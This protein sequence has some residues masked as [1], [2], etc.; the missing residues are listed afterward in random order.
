MPSISTKSKI[1]GTKNTPGVR[2]VFSGSTSKEREEVVQRVIEEGRRA[3]GEGAGGPILVPP[4]DHPDIILGQGTA[5]LEMEEQFRK[6]K[7]AEMSGKDGMGRKACSFAV[8][9]DTIEQN[10][11]TSTTGIESGTGDQP[12]FD[13]VLTPLGGGGLLGGTA[14]WFSHTRSPPP[15]PSSNTT[16][17]KPKGTLIFGT[18]P[19]FQNANDGERSLATSPPER[20]PHVSTLTIADGLRTPVGILPF[21]IISDRNYVEGIYSVSELEIKMAL[22]LVLER[23]K[24]VVEPS[25]AVPLAVVLF[26]EKFRGFV[27]ERQEEE[28]KREGRTGE[29][30]AWDVGI[31]VSGGNT[32]VEALGGLFEEGWLDEKQ[33]EGEDGDRGFEQEREVGVVGR[34]GEKVAEDVAG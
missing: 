2:V 28:M 22:K 33:E 29:K 34:D 5:A 20:I 14:T 21:T 26:C 6:M 11:E 8:S 12:R 19:S 3:N 1:S 17:S 13:A 25:S 15:S 10:H 30:R 31:V 4:Y 24:V 18:E 32:T 27:A 23:M 16:N 7:R 9:D